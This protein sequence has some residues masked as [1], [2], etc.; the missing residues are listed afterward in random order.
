[1]RSFLTW[2]SRALGLFF[3]VMVV[4]TIPFTMGVFHAGRVLFNPELMKKTSVGVVTEADFLPGFVDDVMQ[5][6]EEGEGK[7]EGDPVLKELL[8]R[9]NRAEWERVTAVLLPDEV[10]AEYIEG[11]IDGFY[12]WLDSTQQV[13][14]VTLDLSLVRERMKGPQGEILAQIL[15]ESLPPCDQEEVDA[16]IRDPAAFQSPSDV[17]QLSCKMPGLPREQQVEVYELVLARLAGEIPSRVQVAEELGGGDMGST[18]NITTVKRFLRVI[19]WG[20]RWSWVLP[21]AC[22]FLIAL[23]AVRS[24]GGLGGWW[25]IPITIGSGISLGASWVLPSVLFQLFADRVASR[26]PAY[27][28]QVGMEVMLRVTRDVFHPL[29]RQALLGVILGLLLVSLPVMWDW[30]GKN[31]PGYG[32]GT[33]QIF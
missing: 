19:R 33:E 11:V 30:R 20:G 10:L 22:L 9:L 13:P 27:M 26:F 7:A 3:A 16:F 25:G 4:I 6:G 18:E 17:F 12:N 15:F 24:L 8:L 28:E 5:R 2:I 29:R 23:F 21:L 31:S 14:Q 32:S 1:M